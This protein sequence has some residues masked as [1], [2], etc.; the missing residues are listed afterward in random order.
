MLSM[1][2]LFCF[3]VF[4]ILC[5]VVCEKI[6]IV[7]SKKNNKLHWSNNTEALYRKGQ[8]RLHLLQRLRSLRVCRPLL[9]SFY[10]TV[11]ASVI[12]YAVVSWGAGS[13]ERDR[14]RL[15]K[16][17]KRTSSILECPLD[18]IEEMGERRMLS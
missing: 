1:C 12:F 16:L 11:V 10:D 9:K 15:N 5:C 8:T 18:P 14:K 7:D 2:L 17:V 3:V 13:S 4:W 6:K